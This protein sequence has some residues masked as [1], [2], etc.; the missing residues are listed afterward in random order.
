[1]SSNTDLSPDQNRLLATLTAAFSQIV[2]PLRPAAEYPRAFSTLE[3]S[4][5]SLIGR[6]AYLAA[7]GHVLLTRECADALVSVLQGKRVLDVGAGGGFLSHT[8]AEGGVDVVALEAHPP[9]P[10]PTEADCRR[11]WRIDFTGLAE[12]HPVDGYDAVILAWPDHG[13]PVAAQTAASMRPGQ[14][15]V[16]EGEFGGCTADDSF[17]DEISG[18]H[19]EQMEVETKQLNLHHA[20]FS[21]MRDRWLVLRKV[22]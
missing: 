16:Y 4:M 13:S 2:T 18:K 22:A 10:E 3:E 15:L 9:P 21:C 5:T 11:R 1:M 14:V 20:Q 8:L 6:E 17:F 7:Y 19:W 12:D